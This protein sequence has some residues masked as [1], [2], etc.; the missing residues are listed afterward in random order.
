MNKH[1]GPKK[2]DIYI[3]FKVSVRLIVSVIVFM[4]YF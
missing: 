3:N 2:T 4:V 1:L